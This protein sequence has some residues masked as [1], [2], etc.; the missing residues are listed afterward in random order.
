MLDISTD[1]DSEQDVS[2]LS[3]KITFKITLHNY[4]DEQNFM[5]S[6]VTI[7]LLERTNGCGGAYSGKAD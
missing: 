7:L 3:W 2:R 5:S 6:L 4:D 1:L